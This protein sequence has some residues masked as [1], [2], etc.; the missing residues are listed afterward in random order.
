MS[1]ELTPTDTPEPTPAPEPTPEP[2]PN[3]NP[4][5]TP[6]PEETP[7]ATE[8]ATSDKE[9]YSFDSDDKGD[10]GDTNGDT[11]DGEQH[12]E[13]SVEWPEGYEANEDLTNM[14]NAAAREVGVSDKALGAYTVRMIEQLEAREAERL[15][16]DDADLK[17]AWGKDYLA[18]K[19]AAKEFMQG[20]MKEHGIPAEEAKAFATPQ[21]VKLLY[22][23]SQKLGGG[24]VH[25]GK[26]SADEKAWATAALS[27]RSHPEYKALSDPKDPRHKEVTARYFRA[28][29]AR[30]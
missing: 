17:G 13:Y 29:G 9:D 25:G 16:A 7:G 15:Q 5:P 28:K 21:G 2:A 11:K 30:V 24:A 1:E 6:A 22:A 4:E 26:V 10:S 20:V 3:P 19:K 14:V 18:N 27:D 8:T 12:A 23:L